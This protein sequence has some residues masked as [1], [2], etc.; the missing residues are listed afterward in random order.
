[1]LTPASRPIIQATLPLV[2]A[3]LDA[4][5]ARFYDT[6]LG[7]HPE[8][9]DGLF[10]RANQRSGEQR[11]A[12]AGAIAGYA[13]HLLKDPAPMDPVKR[14]GQ[15]LV[16]RIAHKH[17]SLGITPEQ[18]QLVYDYLFGAIAIELADVLTPEIAAAWTEVYWLMAE[19]LSG[20]EAQLYAANGNAAVW[21]PWRV[22]RKTPAGTHAMSFVVDPV[23]ATAARPGRPGQYVSVKVR[24]ADGIQQTRQYSLSADA[25]S[26]RQ[27]TFTVKYD[28][29]VS[30]A[31]HDD[32]HIGDVIELSAPAGDVAL[33]DSDRP[34]VLAS[35]GI[36][37]TPMAATLRSLSD[38]QSPRK[39]LAL[40]TE[41]RAEHWALADQMRQDV[42]A[43]PDGQLQL[44]FEEP[45]EGAH[46]G[47]MSL[48]DV[49]LPPRAVLHLCG[50]LGFMRAIRQEAI[51]LGIEPE[52]I[53]YEVFGPDLWLASA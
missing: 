14:S 8:L 42:A 12:L 15:Q 20:R 52:H 3:R 37:C 53:H 51:D 27:R 49:A 17:V 16:E 30:R 36:G 26:S 43:L 6:M 45:A 21:S 24:M 22:V 29:E 47:R 46:H 1:M 4:I 19:E 33:G 48:K 39:V 32:V 35:A 5:T 41:R 28:G 38:Q 34:V 23:D 7:E 9:L 44:W 18:Y 13:V 40:H 50:P 2:G 10:N 31:L 25:E 11:Q